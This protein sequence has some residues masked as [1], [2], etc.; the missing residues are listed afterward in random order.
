MISTVLLFSLLPALGAI[1]GAVV[2]VLR[3]PGERAR[4][5]IQLF[6]AGVVFSV[7]GV[8]LLPDVMKRH[9]PIQVIVGFAIGVAVMLAVKAWSER[10]YGP[11]TQDGGGRKQAS[12]GLLVAVGIDVAVDALLLGIGFAA[13]RAVG[14]LLAVALTIELLSLGLAVAAELDEAGTRPVRSVALIAAS[15]L[16]GTAGVPCSRTCGP[17]ASAWRAGSLAPGFWPSCRF[18]PPGPT[19]TCRGKASCSRRCGSLWCSSERARTSS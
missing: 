12:L 10:L 2:A 17:R 14:T 15:G 16:P 19:T 5:Y 4:S 1:G 13:E 11:A 3:A 8:E 18:I 9:E 6:A 7:V